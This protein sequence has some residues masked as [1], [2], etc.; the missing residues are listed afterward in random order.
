MRAEPYKISNVEKINTPALVVYPSIMQQNINT[1][2]TIAGKNILRPH[3]KT[4]KTPEAIKLMQN[5]GIRH[6]KCAT[7]SEAEMLGMLLAEDVL[8]AYQ[9]VGTAVR[10]LKSIID[11]YPA[12]SFS[13]LIDTSASLEDWEN[14]SLAK[15]LKVYLDLNVGM[16][17]TGVSVDNASSLIQSCKVNRNISLKG[18]HAYDGH[19]NDQNINKRKL[20]ADEAFQKA[21]SIKGVAEDICGREMELVIGGTPTF[22]MYA[23]YDNVQ[24]SP[25]TFVFWDWGYSVFSDLPFTPAAILLTRI[26]S[27]INSKWL[28]LDLGHKAVASENPLRKRLKFLNVESVNLVSHSEE[29]LVVEVED[30]SKHV[31][32][33]V[34]YALPY[35]ICPTVAL[36]NELDVIVEGERVQQ[37]QVTARNRKINF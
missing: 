13:C 1:A 27:I 15:P 23:Q 3:V 2:L 29:H 18:I 10:R 35:H 12:T 26:V 4:C 17:R 9:P 21:L 31:L 16:N 7:L 36:Y 6:F 25:G 5:Q 37:W 34:W 32:G 19:I 33:E 22:P 8:L 30:T 14:E 28:C 20:R 24:C 11:A